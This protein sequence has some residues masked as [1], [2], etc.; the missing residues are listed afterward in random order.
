MLKTW[1]GRLLCSLLF[2]FTAH[3]P[4]FEQSSSLCKKEKMSIFNEKWPHDFPYFNFCANKICSR[5]KDSFL[6]SLSFKT[7]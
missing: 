5:A 2:A 3:G 6:S 4:A 1:P 7:L